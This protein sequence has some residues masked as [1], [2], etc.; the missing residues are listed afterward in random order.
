M[1]LDLEPYFREYE[2]LAAA[3]DEVFNKVREQYAECVTCHTGCADCCHALFDLTLIE[4]LYV[5]R[6][7]KENL[8]QD[9]QESLLERANRADRKIYKLKRQAYKSLKEGRR[10]EAQVLAEMA[11]YKVRCPLLNDEDLCDLYDFRPITCRFYGIPTAINGKAHTCGLSG[12][13]PGEPYPTVH[14]E[15]IQERLYDLSARLISEINSRYP[16]L[17]ELLVPLSMA[18]LTRY[19]DAYLGV[20]DDQ[21]G[22]ESDE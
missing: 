2:A 4:A 10:D 11:E 7:F 3:A 21:D 14:L 9:R 16:K 18:L 15:K 20:G 6:H 13:Q 22:G 5:N 1:N 17:S 19:D 12:F 8:S